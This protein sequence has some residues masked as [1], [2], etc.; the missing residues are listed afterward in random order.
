MKGNNHD[1]HRCL[2]VVVRVVVGVVVAVVIVV[3]VVVGVVAV[4]V[5]HVVVAVVV[6]VC[7]GSWLWLGFER[8]RCRF[9]FVWGDAACQCH[10]INV[11]GCGCADAV[12]LWWQNN[13]K[14][15]GCSETKF[16]Q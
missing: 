7:V 5:I 3:R 10:V 2:R 16:G 11:L 1:S 6:F 13:E 8:C 9:G 14:N 4:V 12:R 15:I